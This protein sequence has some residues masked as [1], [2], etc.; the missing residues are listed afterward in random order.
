AVAELSDLIRTKFRPKRMY[1]DRNIINHL[2]KLFVTWDAAM[3]IREIETVH[4]SAKLL[5]T[6]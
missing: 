1:V 3:I 5:I 4:P 2:G 6:M